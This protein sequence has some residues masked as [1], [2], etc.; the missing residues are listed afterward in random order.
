MANFRYVILSRLSQSIKEIKDYF[1]VSLIEPR[2]S[3]F[4]LDFFKEK[5]SQKVLIRIDIYEFIV[6]V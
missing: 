4:V 6:A 5:G 1:T 3:R 2:T